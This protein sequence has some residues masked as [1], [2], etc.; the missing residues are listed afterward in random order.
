MSEPTAT[1][2][3]APP[4]L[5]PGWALFLDVDGCLLDFADQPEDVHVP[6]GLAEALTG[7]HDA[8]GG[9]V[10]FVSGRA[11]AQ[12]DG[13]FA[14]LRLACAGLHGLELRGP[15][16]VPGEPVAAAPAL[17]R[18]RER[19]E[20]IAAAYPGARV[21]DKGAALALHWRAAPDA[22]EAFGAFAKQAIDQLPGYRLQPGNCVLELRPGHADKGAAVQRLMRS[23][24]FAGRMPVYA[25]DDLTDEDGFV[26]ADAL[27]GLSVIVGDRR[28]T[29]A[30]FALAD[31]TALRAWLAEGARRLQ[32]AA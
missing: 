16:G 2:L 15:D 26:A 7:L 23:P 19:A 11:I 22:R 3:P 1:R 6:E 30:R 27:Q 25:G 13:L 29:A 17:A 28:P 14:P 9:A 12:L 32:E 10:A 8:L 31:T 4:P 5:E 24:P 18:V 21:E 20:A